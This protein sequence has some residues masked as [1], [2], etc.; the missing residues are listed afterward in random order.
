MG[1]VYGQIS[2]TPLATADPVSER[3]KLPS[4]RAGKEVV[5][6]APGNNAQSEVGNSVDSNNRPQPDAET[7]SK[8]DWKQ[9]NLR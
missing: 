9:R 6:I 3:G 5:K 1:K 2:R 4:D 8:L 7:A